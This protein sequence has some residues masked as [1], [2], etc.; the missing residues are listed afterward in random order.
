MH[1][2]FLNN[3]LDSYA[4]ARVTGTL[5]MLNIN[6]MKLLQQA[7]MSLRRQEAKIADVGNAAVTIDSSR[8]HFL[9]RED[10]MDV[11]PKR[12]VIRGFS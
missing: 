2:P 1:R 9:A 5:Q 7:S 12:S 3:I 10:A 11:R 8:V 4:C 6:E